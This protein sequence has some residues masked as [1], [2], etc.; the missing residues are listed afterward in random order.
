MYVAGI[1][2][3]TQRGG[4]DEKKICRICDEV[5]TWKDGPEMDYREESERR[6]FRHFPLTRHSSK[7]AGK[8][9]EKMPC[10]E[11]PSTPPAKELFLSI[12]QNL[13]KATSEA[14]FQTVRSNALRDATIFFGK[15]ITSEIERKLP[16]KKTS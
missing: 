9:G 10:L 4:R 2:F 5:R 12:P 16:K 14:E 6:R 15:Q 11:V 7:G 8:V 13:Y 3:Q 1:E